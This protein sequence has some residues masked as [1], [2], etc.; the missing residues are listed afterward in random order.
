MIQEE[1]EYTKEK[2]EAIKIV[3]FSV[4]LGVAII[5][6]TVVIVCTLLSFYYLPFY[7]LLLLFTLIIAILYRS[8]LIEII[9]NLSSLTV[10]K[11]KKFAAYSRS[12]R[13]VTKNSLLLLLCNSDCKVLKFKL[14]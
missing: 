4:V 14:E 3:C 5:C 9:Q 10:C 8:V 2:A 7:K 11:K 12:K 6:S 1:S 13:K